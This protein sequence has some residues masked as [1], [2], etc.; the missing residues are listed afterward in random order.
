MKIELS[1]IVAILHNVALHRQARAS[2]RDSL[3]QCFVHE[4][5]MQ[6]EPEMQTIL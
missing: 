6:R 4:S 3:G 2:A 5:T 1:N